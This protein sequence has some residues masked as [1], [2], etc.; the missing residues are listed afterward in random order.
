MNTPVRSNTSTVYKCSRLLKKRSAHNRVCE[1]H[2]RPGA[3]IC[4]V[5]W[6]RRWVIFDPP[7]EGGVKN[8]HFLHCG[9][10]PPGG[11]EI[12]PRILF[13][14]IYFGGFCQAGYLVPKRFRSD[15]AQGAFSVLGPQN[16]GIGENRQKRP[17]I[18]VRGGTPHCHF[19]QGERAGSPSHRSRCSQHLAGCGRY[20]LTHDE[21]ARG[22]VFIIKYFYFIQLLVFVFFCPTMFGN[23]NIIP[24]SVERFCRV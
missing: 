19:L 24:Q 4:C 8:V 12:C 23:Q 9:G 10:P 3:V 22:F 15:A 11:G 21:V 16:P 5:W 6:Q 7:P 13:S 20:S 14:T 2:S 1:Q 18:G 17:K